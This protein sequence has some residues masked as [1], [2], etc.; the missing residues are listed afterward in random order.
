[1]QLKSASGSARLVLNRFCSGASKARMLSRQGPVSNDIPERRAMR[2]FSMHLPASVRVSGI[3][4]PFQT[5]TE[6][7]SARG[8]FF[9]IDRLMTAGTQVEVTMEFPPQVTLAEP[10]RVR[11]VA[12]VLRVQEESTMR[13]GVA[14]EIEEYEFLAAENPARAQALQPGWNSAG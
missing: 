12:R 7:V 14:A 4:T 1:L 9:Y 10:L 2:R 6:N 11:F 5:H 8:V 3:P 13:V